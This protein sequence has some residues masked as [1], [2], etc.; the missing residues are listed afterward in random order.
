MA[1]RPE[2]GVSSSKF[3]S[4][5][6]NRMPRFG[7]THLNSSIKQYGLPSKAVD[8]PTNVDQRFEDIRVLDELETKF[9]FDRYEGGPERLG[10][11][12]NMHAVRRTF[13]KRE[14]PY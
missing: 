10:W 5:G 13:M 14:T 12:I 2:F 3:S 7:S 8:S 1:T 6:N 9:G 4:K 11:L